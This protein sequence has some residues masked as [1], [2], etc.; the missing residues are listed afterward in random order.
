MHSHKKS[1]RRGDTVVGSFTAIQ[2]A[3]RL[4][5]SWGNGRVVGGGFMRIKSCVIA[6]ALIAFSTV[7]FAQEDSSH[8]K[9]W[10][11]PSTIRPSHPSRPVTSRRV[12]LHSPRKPSE[13]RELQQLE[14][15]TYR[16]A[17]TSAK[18]GAA[19]SRDPKAA[20][21]ARNPAVNFRYKA[22]RNPSSRSGTRSS[23]AM[24]SKRGYHH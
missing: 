21:E 23:G 16:N 18:R 24:T 4:S 10:T 2:R 15:Q 6:L 14:S 11:T 22:P 5:T 17:G 19:P 7:L 1:P 20:R 13:S 12:R 8:K 3:A 9:S